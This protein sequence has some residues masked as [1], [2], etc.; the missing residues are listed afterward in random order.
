ME[1]DEYINLESRVSGRMV[2][3]DVSA[4]GE[5][6][7]IDTSNKEMN[8]LSYRAK[9]LKELQNKV[10][11]LEDVNGSISITDLTL[12]D[13]RM[14][15]TNYLKDNSKLLEKSPT[16]IHSIVINDNQEF[17][18]QFGKGVI[19]CIKM[20]DN[21]D[22]INADKYSLEPY[23]LIFVDENNEIKYDFSNAKIILDFMKKVS[24][25]K[26]EIDTKAIDIF[27]KETKNYNDMSHYIEGLDKAI[28]NIVGK[29]EEK[30][31]SSLFSRGGTN[32]STQNS[33]KVE[34]ELISYMVIK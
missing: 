3:L 14:D 16:A 13:F 1:L 34:F 23:Y 7:V 19:Y 29:K 28:E 2:L 24:L 20:L 32:I 5:E 10:I 21:T 26:K 15:L 17:I 8:D 12:N 18:K 6:N 27:E 31:I 4:T 11:D 9:Q 33:S 25:N 30:G 22:N